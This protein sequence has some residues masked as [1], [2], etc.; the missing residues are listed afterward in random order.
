MRF[1]V[2]DGRVRFLQHFRRAQRLPF[3]SVQNHAVEIRRSDLENAGFNSADTRER[4][5][6]RSLRLRRCLLQ[7]KTEF[8]QHI[9]SDVLAKRRMQDDSLPQDRCGQDTRRALRSRAAGHR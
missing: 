2:A 8:P 6:G 4:Q 7:I 3:V 1:I 9:D 5:L